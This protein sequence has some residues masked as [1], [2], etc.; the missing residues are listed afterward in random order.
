MAAVAKF[1][2]WISRWAL[3]LA[4]TAWANLPSLRASD[5]PP[6]CPRSTAVQDRPEL[7]RLLQPSLQSPGERVDYRGQI[8][9]TLAGSPRLSH[10]CVWIEPGSR[11]RRWQPAIEA[12]LTRWQEVL[13]IERVPDPDQAQVLVV[14]RRPPLVHREGRQRASHGRTTLTSRYV[15]RAGR[16]RLEPSL[17]VMVDSTQRQEG[18]QATALHELGHAFGL[19][20]HSPD[21]GD[22]M[23]A[24]PGARPLLHL[25]PRDLATLN[26]LYRQPTTYGRLWTAVPD[27]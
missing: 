21:Q 11:E 17:V 24:T 8:Q 6:A 14:H 15:N 9:T 2:P 4:V 16:W 13:P 25:S 20:G 1:P 5:L 19:W 12:A 10:W 3:G 27:P 7:A 22:V 26:W 18:I 23:A